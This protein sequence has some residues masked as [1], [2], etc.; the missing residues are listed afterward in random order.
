MR[1]AAQPA[2]WSRPS[3]ALM[4]FVRGHTAT[5]AGPT[6]AVVGT[7]LSAVNQGGVILGGHAEAAPECG[8]R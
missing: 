4:P 8:S 1:T 6:A 2:T 3:Q 7:V 5:T